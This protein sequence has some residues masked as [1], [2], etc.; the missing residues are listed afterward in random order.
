MHFCRQFP[1]W[2]KF[3]VHLRNFYPHINFLEGN[4]CKPIEFLLVYLLICVSNVQ[5]DQM[6]LMMTISKP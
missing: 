6:K 2:P 1:T 5:V 4:K 3:D